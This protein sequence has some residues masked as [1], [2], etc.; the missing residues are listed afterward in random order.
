MTYRE[1]ISQV[2][3]LFK[4]VN[5]DSRFS[6]K[7]AYSLIKKH[8]KWIIHR[9]SEKLKLRNIDSLFQSMKCIKVIEAPIIDPCCGLRIKGCTMY[10]TQNKLPDI[11]EDG[12]GAIIN[13]VTSVDGWTTINITTAKGIKRRRNLPYVKKNNR[14]DVFYS[15][16]YIYFPDKHLKLVEISAMFLGEVLKQENCEP[17]K[18]CEQICKKFLDTMWIIPGYLEAQVMDFVKKDIADTYSQIPE[19]SHEINKNTNPSQ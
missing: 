15:D 1:A 11:Y 7:L 13:K 12:Y 8:S 10:R 19:K 17:C 3:Q 16:G 9:D 5:A 6:K 4:E 2:R 18:D 14:I